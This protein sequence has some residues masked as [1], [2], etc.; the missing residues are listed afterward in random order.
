M[1]WKVKFAS[2]LLFSF[3]GNPCFSAGGFEDFLNEY[4]RHNENVQQRF[5]AYKK[6]QDEDFANFLSGAWREFEALQGKPRMPL[7]EP[8]RAPVYIS[9]SQSGIEKNT[10][11]G[12]SPAPGKT[13][14]KAPMPPKAVEPVPL[15][16]LEKQPAAIVVDGELLDLGF[17]GN[18]LKLPVDPVWRT[19]RLQG[20]DTPAAISA[21]WTSMSSSRYQPAVDAF[22]E[23]RNRF[24]LDDWA[25]VQ[26]WQRYVGQLQPGNE[27]VRQLQLWFFLVKA[28]LDSRIA[29]FNDEI[30]VLMAVK[31]QVYE[32]PQF[33]F[34]G[35][36][37]YPIFAPRFG[38]GITSFYSYDARYPDKL[39]SLEMGSIN[40]DFAKPVLAK[41]KLS[42][43]FQGKPVEV[44]ANYNAAVIPYF[45]AV[46]PLDFET[47][48]ASQ[49]SRVLRDN[50]LPELK[51]LT[52]KMPEDAAVQF[53]LT[54]VQ[55]SFDYKTNAEQFGR[56]KAFFVDDAFYFPYSDCKA[57][58]V[59]FSWLVRNVLGLNVVGL[60]YDNHLST[61]VAMKVRK[62]D[63]AAIEHDGVTYVYADPT[64]IGAPV[65]KQQREYQGKKPIR[66][67]KI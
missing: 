11:K 61:A 43:N 59:L 21:F 25:W 66:V 57:R 2:A 41:R 40:A 1:T 8:E 62:P 15:V 38:R 64:Y 47:Y 27:T 19:Y 10:N 23:Y 20:G 31:Q 18:N 12:S 35:K 44:S 7:P 30:Y 67:V 48:F 37:Y 56:E 29:Y 34:D 4:N 49:G 42:F 26:L 55:Q 51:K 17:Y 6:K 45:D 65:G 58:A 60:H 50:L 33:R 46:P 13:V 24:Q 63:W 9:D 54:L 53:L 32:S 28:G 22:V 5:T 3:L 52:H 36:V 14:F 16:N 39:R